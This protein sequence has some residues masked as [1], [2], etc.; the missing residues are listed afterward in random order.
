MM[1]EIAAAIETR[2]DV[3]VASVGGGGLLNGI[4]LG[5]ERA[6]W[7]DVPIVAMETVGAHCFNAAV[8]A[9][10]VVTLPRIT[11]CDIYIVGIDPYMCY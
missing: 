11:R 9:G 1:D 8:K 6:G 3:V 10:K 4:V 5:M 7:K 2:P